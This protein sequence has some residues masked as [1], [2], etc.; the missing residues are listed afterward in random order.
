MKLYFDADTVP[1]SSVLTVAFYRTLIDDPTKDQK[2]YW[3]GQDANGVESSSEEYCGPFL[4]RQGADFR[5]SITVSATDMTV[6]MSSAETYI[7]QN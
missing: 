3:K 6:S 7:G 2:A 5:L 1:L 4:L